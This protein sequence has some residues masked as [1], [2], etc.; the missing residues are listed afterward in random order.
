MALEVAKVKR[1]FLMGKINVETKE[2]ESSGDDHSVGEECIGP[3]PI[4]KPSL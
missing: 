3:S 1:Q 4:E 2:A